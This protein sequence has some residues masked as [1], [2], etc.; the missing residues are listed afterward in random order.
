MWL[1]NI[2]YY[3]F[4]LVY[5]HKIVVTII[6]VIEIIPYYLSDPVTIT[7][8]LDFC[9]YNYLFDILEKQYQDA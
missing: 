5:E 3:V 1:T 8:V 9:M 6:N 7:L 4:I 2:I